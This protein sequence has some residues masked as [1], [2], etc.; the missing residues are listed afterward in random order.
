MLSKKKYA[1]L[2]FSIN[3]S[4]VGYSAFTS[5]KASLN[6]DNN[7]LQDAAYLKLFKSQYAYSKLQISREKETLTYLL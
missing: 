1:T 4:T 7:L 2:Y 3:D 5:T 6:W